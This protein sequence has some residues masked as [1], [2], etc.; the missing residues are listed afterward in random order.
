MSTEDEE[1][2]GKMRNI[3]I[4]NVA[5]LSFTN[6]RLARALAINRNKL[7]LLTKDATGLTT[8]EYVKSIRLE[9]AKKYLE[10]KTYSTV[11]RVA[12]EV[13]FKRIDYFVTLYKE[14]Y[15]KTPSAYFKTQGAVKKN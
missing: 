4:Q 11:T 13:G 8:N 14:A 3:I 5:D 7:Y 10:N 2:F 6:D 1:L 12:N 9:M 15:G